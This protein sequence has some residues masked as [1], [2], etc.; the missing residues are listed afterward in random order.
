MTKKAE[1][2]I[3]IKMQK[4]EDKTM[5]GIDEKFSLKKMIANIEYRDDIPPLWR[6]E[7]SNGSEPAAHAAKR[8]GI[9]K[10]QVLNVEEQSTLLLPKMKNLKELSSLEKEVFLFFLGQASDKAAYLAFR[11][12]E[13]EELVGIENLVLQKV[14]WS[15]QAKG[16]IHLGTIHQ[17]STD[18]DWNYMLPN[19]WKAYGT[20][21][22]KEERRRRYAAAVK[23]LQ[24]LK[25]DDFPITR[26][27]FDPRNNLEL[28][29]YK[30][31]ITDDELLRWEYPLGNL[32]VT[33]DSEA[34][35]LLP[36]PKANRLIGLSATQV[37]VLLFLLQQV[38]P[39]NQKLVVSNTTMSR[40]LELDEKTI[41]SAVAAL[42]EKGFIHRHSEKKPSPNG[43][44]YTFRYFIINYWKL[45][46]TKQNF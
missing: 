43:G 38:A 18:Q 3:I 11:W 12:E 37:L 31:K 30:D 1:C 32:I 25:N 29:K 4:Q 28:L 36:M 26:V 34:P 13:I 17:T 15:L 2:G 46:G 45:Y 19:Y 16:F 6:L 5:N 22:P 35:P 42:E 8:R 33:R 24:E 44:V 21:P 14:L 7:N 23:Q 39:N 20:I 10:I 9:K 40:V 41:S 27:L